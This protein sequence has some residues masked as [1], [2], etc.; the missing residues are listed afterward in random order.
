MAKKTKK[1]EVKEPQLEKTVTEFFEE[2][3]T[4]EP[5]VETPVIK[6]PKSKTSVF[7]RSL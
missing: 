7:T 4:Q 3:V 1:V 6:T 2:T 5:K